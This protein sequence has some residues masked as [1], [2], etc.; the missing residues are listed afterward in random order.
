[1]VINLNKKFVTKEALLEELTDIE[2]YQMYLPEAFVFNKTIKSP[3]RDEENASF[4]FFIGENGE[5][6]F[7]DF[8]LGAG[9]CIKFVQLKFGLDFFEAMS[10]IVLDAN[11]DGQFIIKNTFKTNINASAQG[12]S[13][14][15]MIASVNSF[16][17]GKKAREFH[18]YD[19][20]FWSL[21][22]I[23]HKTL[24]RYRVQP[25]SHLFYGDKIVVA[26]RLSYA[27][28]E[29]KDGKVTYKIYQ[30]ESDHY[31]WINNHNESVWQG[32]EQLPEKGEILIITKSLKDVMAINDV[33]GIPAVS[34]QA[35]GV[36]P[37]QQVIDEL[38]S[39]FEIIFLLYDNDYDKEVNWGQEFGA[40][41]ALKYNIAQIEIHK[42]Y[43]S[44]DF[45][46][47]V[48]AKGKKIAKEVLAE[49]IE[50]PF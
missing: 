27:F 19:F 45:S 14:E 5:V 33:C 30:P 2:I 20:A 43:R 40:K 18:L 23:T 9:D 37:K 16:K 47:L 10:K 17:L 26:E 15:K 22:G 34:L 49:L 4:G 29:R 11:L 48:A 13:R 3:L 7:K 32:W 24:L 35:E 1:M 44:K 21:F 25:V 31:K 39:R 50:I 28:E 6:C 42:S 41:I 38:K 12:T 8:L 36:M 46:D